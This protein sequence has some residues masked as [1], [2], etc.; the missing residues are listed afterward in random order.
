[1][2]IAI[3]IS[4][5][6][7]EGTGVATYTRNLV[8]SLLRLDKK[9]EYILFGV[10]FRHVNILETFFTK[11]QQI[12][13]G[14]LK[15]FVLLPP[16]LMNIIW[17]S[18][19]IFPVETLLGPIDIFHSSDWTAPPSR[20]KKV[21]TIHDL[22]VY[23]FPQTSDSYIISTQKKRLEWVKKE[24]DCIISDSYATRDD[25]MRFLKIPKQK[26]HV[27]Y[28]GI[29]KEFTPQPTDEVE[30]VKRKYALF[31]DYLL[32][33]GTMEPRKNLPILFDAFA[34]F[35]THSLIK[36]LRKPIELIVAGK[37]G[38]G[39]EKHSSGKFVR[40]LGF[41]HQNDLPAL[42][43]GASAFIYPSLYEGFG[44]PILEAMACG[45]PVITSQRGSLRE[46]V[47]GH[48]LTIDP[49]DPHD[50]SQKMVQCM[51]D[52]ELRTR[53]VKDAKTYVARFNWISY[54]RKIINI[55]GTIQ[56]DSS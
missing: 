15:K 48:G 24:N 3:D 52:G 27:L 43:S 47:D 20:A 38:W 30:R 14:V 32:S 53:L 31:D 10:A 55:Y 5:I 40:F 36:A 2:R 22:V 16:R 11:V 42:Y 19:H 29:S 23:T 8:E 7:Y 49:A 17:N 9:N 37:G 33:V 21:T 41:V 26:I 34:E 39:G 51:V 45:C 50:I 6:V 18:W 28:P 1:M 13:P 54:A 12:R 25:I 35:E 46:L 4:Q 44:L 56:K